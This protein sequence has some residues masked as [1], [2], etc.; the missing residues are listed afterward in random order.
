MKI[1][2]HF[3][4]QVCAQALPPNFGAQDIAKFDRTDACRRVDGDRVDAPLRYVDGREAAGLTR[5]AQR[6]AAEY[7]ELAIGV[8]RLGDQVQVG[9]ATGTIVTAS[10]DV[11]AG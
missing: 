1:V 10:T 5:A 7:A 9:E 11:L 4:P 3:L 6:P 2:V 8:A